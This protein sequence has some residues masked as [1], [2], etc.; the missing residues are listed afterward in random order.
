MTVDY[1]R[2]LTY[3]RTMNI[4]RQADAPTFETPGATFQGYAAPSRGA[5]E[6]SMWSL[7][8]APGST[9]PVHHMDSEEVFLG[10]SGT[11]E[12]TIDCHTETLGA[13]DCLVLPAGTLFS[14]YVPEDAGP[15]RA[16]ACMRA[17]GQAIMNPAGP[18][19]APPWA[20]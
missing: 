12:V 3:G 11:A 15:F 19:F 17:G 5:G 8:L 14:F 1:Q 10:L 20:E 2:T 18:Q 13:G 9:S 6:V 16:T 4:I 7:E